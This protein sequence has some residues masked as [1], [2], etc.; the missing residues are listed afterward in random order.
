[1]N[2][3]L[4]EEI[5]A[6]GQHLQLVHGDI[7]LEVVDAVVNAANRFLQH[8]GGVARAIVCRGG[9]QIQEESNQWIK[10]HGPI[11]HA[12]PAYTSA[13]R[14]SC[15]YVIHAVGPTWGEG[16]EEAKLATAVTGS[17]QLADRLGVTSLALPAISTGIFGFP[18][19]RAAEVILGAVRRYLLKNRDS[20]LRLVRLTIYDLET[21]RVFKQSWHSP[22][23]LDEYE[24]A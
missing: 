17:L 8:G 21:L 2:D 11:T 15:R 16:D 4:F 22:S 10:S 19:A 13:G 12:E 7:T 20:D 1:M 14:I 24:G 23:G 6:S 5:L 3:I 9:D 18:K